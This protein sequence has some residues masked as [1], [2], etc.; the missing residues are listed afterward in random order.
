[1]C[2]FRKTLLWRLKTLTE[3][4]EKKKPSSRKIKAT[5]V[6]QDL[7]DENKCDVKI[8][9]TAWERK[10]KPF[11][12]RRREKVKRS[13]TGE[14]S[15]ARSQWAFL[16]RNREKG[17]ISYE[18]D[19]RKGVSRKESSAEDS[20]VCW[21]KK[22]VVTPELVVPPNIITRLWAPSAYTWLANGHPLQYHPAFFNLKKFPLSLLIKSLLF[23]LLHLLLNRL[24]R[25]ISGKSKS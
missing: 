9:T 22:D 8:E 12:W 16:E 10:E 18:R 11:E 15:Q 20:S 6:S 23:L 13:A 1:M 17:E 2:L 7:F 5:S 25:P 3:L 19:L 21:T 14:K 4:R 24:H